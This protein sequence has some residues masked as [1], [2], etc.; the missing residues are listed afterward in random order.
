[1]KGNFT[2]SGLASRLGASRA[3][4]L[5]VE[6]LFSDYRRSNVV[7]ASSG[8]ARRMQVADTQA[9]HD[10]D[11]EFFEQELADVRRANEAREAHGDGPV[12]VVVLT[13]HAPSPACCGDEHV[14]EV[15]SHGSAT[16]LRHMFVDPLR[17]WA[18]GHTHQVIDHWQ[19]Q[20]RLASN[21]RGYV[22]DLTEGYRNDFVLH[23]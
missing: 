12:P 22:H 7:D 6:Y 20:T 11:I 19:G 18:C 2:D 17:A 15:A 14:N 16:E 9:F 23:I 1:V 3:Q 13:H 4:E 8:D 5:F 21:A 10:A